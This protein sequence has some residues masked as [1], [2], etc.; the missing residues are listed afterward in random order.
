MRAM[1]APRIITA[2]DLALEFRDVFGP[3]GYAGRITG[4]FSGGPRATNDRHAVDILRRLHVDHLGKGWGGCGYHYVIADDGTLLCVRPIVLQGAHVGGHNS[5]NVGVLCPGGEGD[6]P[7]V[8]Q[9]ATYAWL[10]AHAHTAAMPERHRPEGDLRNARAYAHHHWHGHTTNPCAGRYEEMFL[11]GLDQPAPGEEA[12]APDHHVRPTAAG[13]PPATEFHGIVADGRHV[14]VLEAY[15]AAG[16]RERDA[17]AGADRGGLMR[18]C[19]SG[20]RP[21]FRPGG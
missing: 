12:E 15:R 19:L 13:Y 8:E 10:L 6:R 1:P 3:L 20:E 17:R 16:S 2:D 11:A 7:T 5:G 21:A 9:R 14:S 4:H 18:P